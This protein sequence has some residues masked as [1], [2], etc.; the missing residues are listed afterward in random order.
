MTE[1]VD[2][3]STNIEGNHLTSSI[4]E[5]ELISYNLSIALAFQ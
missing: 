3:K 4:A 2:A 1:R 5:R